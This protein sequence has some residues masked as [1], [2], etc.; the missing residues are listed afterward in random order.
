MKSPKKERKK[1]QNRLRSKNQNGR[2]ETE[3][4][5]SEGEFIGR[6]LRE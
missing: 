2:S 1:A 3:M 4:T 6:V 5:R